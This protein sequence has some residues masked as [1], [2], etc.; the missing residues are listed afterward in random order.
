MSDMSDISDVS[1]DEC[2]PELIELWLG[3]MD[4]ADELNHIYDEIL[5]RL[6]NIK[7]TVEEME[8]SQLANVNYLRSNIDTLIVTL[9]K[10]LNISDDTD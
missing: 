4:D 10:Q 7:S 9:A 1:D 3:I 8:I 5:E 6:N 2:T